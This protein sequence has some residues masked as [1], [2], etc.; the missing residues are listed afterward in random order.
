MVDK[1]STD[2]RVSFNEKKHEYRDVISKEK[3]TS[4]T[5]LIH[6]LFPPFDEKVMARKLASFAWAKAQKK[7]VRYWLAEWKKNRE[8]GT[9]C[10]AE[11]EKFLLDQEGTESLLEVFHPR[12]LEGIKYLKQLL[13][14]FNGYEIIPEMLIYGEGLAGQ[15]DLVLKDHDNV[16]I[17]DWKFTKRIKKDS[18]EK[19]ETGT[20]PITSHLVNC[21]YNT[22][23]LQLSVY[24]Y[25]LE[26]Q[27]YHPERLILVHIDPNGKVT[28]YEIDYHR[29]VAKELV[30]SVKND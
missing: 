11:I 19:G 7:G 15:S 2:G 14:S 8:E 27:G 30:E 29:S 26:L 6:S 5:T 13:K 12:S 1:Y 21:N 24:A 18:Y 28:P 17:V 10:H 9:L 23:S 22:Y 16:T 25:L 20:S 4:V 3:L